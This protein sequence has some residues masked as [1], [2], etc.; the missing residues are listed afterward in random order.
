MQDT[1]AA[2]RAF[3]CEQEFRTFAVELRSPGQQLLDG[4]RPFLHQRADRHRIAQAVAGG[5]RVLFVQTGF[6]VIA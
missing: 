5:Q 1:V 6:I 4:G 2:V 3:A